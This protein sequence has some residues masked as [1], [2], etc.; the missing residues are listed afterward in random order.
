MLCHMMYVHRYICHFGNMT[1]LD[2]IKDGYSLACTREEQDK[3]ICFLG[4]WLFEVEGYGFLWR[5]MLGHYF[6]L[7]TKWAGAGVA[8]FFL[9]KTKEFLYNPVSLKTDAPMG[10]QWP[11]PGTSHAQ[12]SGST[13]NTVI[14]MRTTSSV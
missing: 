10:L 4:I 2:Q 9:T 3:V 8:T 12:K 6:Q 1:S 5:W 7:E 14:C 13:V 11:N